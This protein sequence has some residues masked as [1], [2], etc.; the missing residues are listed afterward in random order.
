MSLEDD[1]RI[2]QHL[3]GDP[4]FADEHDLRVGAIREVVAD[5]L[6]VYEQQLAEMR[7]EIA[8]ASA[9]LGQQSDLQLRVTCIHEAAELCRSGDGL[10]DIL[11]TAQK[12]Y[13][14]ARGNVGAVDTEGATSADD[15][16]RQAP[17]DVSAG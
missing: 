13:D 4:W 14:W 3:A 15:Q 2:C 6:K 10:G 9:M 7:C 8:R 12:L 17:G 5:L 16:M 11:E 1:A